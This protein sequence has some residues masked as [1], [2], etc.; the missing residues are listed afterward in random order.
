MIIKK[1]ILIVT[2][3]SDEI[4]HIA[5]K[6]RE[7]LKGNKVVVKSALEFAG[8][9]I[10]PADVFFLGCQNPKPES[11]A[12]LEDLLKHINLAGRP[13]GIF[14]AG[15][16]KTVKYLSSL[17][18]DSEAVLHPVALVDLHSS[19]AQIKKWAEKVILCF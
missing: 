8:N 1:N 18:K 2:D 7:A 14:S 19:G 4:T 11:F 3:D 17:V 5:A 9:D 16:E 13:C 10:L 12:Y 6:I 15:S